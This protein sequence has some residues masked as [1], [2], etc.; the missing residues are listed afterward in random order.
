MGRHSGWL[1]LALTLWLAPGAHGQT[2]TVAQLSG[3]VL[4][5]SGAALPGAESASPR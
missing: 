5:E 4:D 3:T 1:V 2:V